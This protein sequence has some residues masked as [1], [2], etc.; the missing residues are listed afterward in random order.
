MVN[1]IQVDWTDLPIKDIDIGTFLYIAYLLIAA[2]IAVRVLSWVL[3]KLSERAGVYRISVTMAIPLLKITIYTITL[4]LFVTALIEPSL[5]QLVAFAG[6]FGAALGFGLKDIFADV[7]GGLVIIFERPYQIGDKITAQNHY[8]EVIDIGLRS[9]RIRTPDDSIVTIPNYIVFGE[10]VESANAG[11]TEMMVV[12]DLYIDSESDAELAMN[13]LKD[14]V[15]TSKF[16][17]ITEKLPYTILLDDFPFYKRVR[18]RVYVNE[19]RY[20][21]E[22]MSEVTRRSWMAYSRAGIRPPQVQRVLP[23]KAGR[24]ERTDGSL[25]RSNS[26]NLSS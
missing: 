14:A 20:E 7:I 3:M 23:E 11:K 21:F 18:A 22:F 8:G 19:L 2:Y 6:L 4:Y 25:N 17:Y 10:S 15:V 13:I 5:S 26:G 24:D 12:I 9:T 1:E 16:A